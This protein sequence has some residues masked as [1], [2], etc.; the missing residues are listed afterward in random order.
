M[1]ELDSLDG[2]S[3][4]KSVNGVG[5]GPF[6]LALFGKTCAAVDFFIFSLVMI[7]TYALA[8][9]TRISEVNMSSLGLLS[10]TFFLI[11]WHI[12]PK[13]IRVKLGG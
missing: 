6:V 2:I 9:S 7:F 8:T 12:L 11:L 1:A 4:M 3:M 10:S 13:L 5:L